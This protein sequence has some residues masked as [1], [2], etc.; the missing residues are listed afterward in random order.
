MW[1]RELGGLGVYAKRE[2]EGREAKK[3]KCRSEEVEKKK[4]GRKETFFGGGAG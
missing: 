4:D 1:Q 3:M 2:R